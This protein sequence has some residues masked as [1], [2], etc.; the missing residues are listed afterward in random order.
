[1]SYTWKNLRRLNPVFPLPHI[2]SMLPTWWMVSL[3]LQQLLV[4]SGKYD[5]GMVDEEEDE[6]DKDDDVVLVILT[7]S[8]FCV[9]VYMCWSLFHLFY[10]RKQRGRNEKRCISNPIHIFSRLEYSLDWSSNHWQNVKLVYRWAFDGF[11]NLPRAYLVV[12]YSCK[13]FVLTGPRSFV[14]SGS[15]TGPSMVIWFVRIVHGSMFFS[16]VIPLPTTNI[17]RPGTARTNFNKVLVP[18]E[19]RCNSIQWRTILRYRTHDLTGG[20]LKCQSWS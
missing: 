19:F 15:L 9:N 11:D 14:L 20:V 12:S 4:R 7:W 17:S 6:I 5:D 10:E 2:T 8:L 18:L 16:R 3:V 13:E 1:M